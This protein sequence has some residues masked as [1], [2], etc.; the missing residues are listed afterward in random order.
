MTGSWTDGGCT[1]FD[2]EGRCEEQN[3]IPARAGKGREAEGRDP[4][5]E[6]GTQDWKSSWWNW[7]KLISNLCRYEPGGYWSML[8]RSV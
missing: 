1:A 7:M 5:T 4:A 6:Q 2:G 8:T 3:G